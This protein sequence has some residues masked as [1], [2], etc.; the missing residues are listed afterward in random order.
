MTAVAP[1]CGKCREPDMLYG[2]NGEVE[3]SGTLELFKCQHTCTF[4][5]FVCS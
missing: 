3:F 5:H 1:A 2:K 4:T